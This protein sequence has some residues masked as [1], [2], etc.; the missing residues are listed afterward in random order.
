MEILEKA[1][2]RV[3]GPDRDAFLTSACSDDP[4]LKKQ[5]IS[6]L[7]SHESAGDFLVKTVLSPSALI[8]DEPGTLIARYRI[9]EKLGEGGCGVVYVAEQSEPCGAVS[10]SR[11]SNWEWIPSKL[12]LASR[13]S[14]RPSP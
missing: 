9:L 3:A 8:T 10:R 7:Q 13:L 12:F 1:E 6:L 11:S 2:S 14:G 4:E 5:V